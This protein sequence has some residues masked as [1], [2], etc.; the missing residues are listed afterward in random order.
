MKILIDSI[1]NNSQKTGEITIVPPLLLQHG[2]TATI[3]DYLQKYEAA[4]K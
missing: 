4:K 1:Q 3:N 2:D